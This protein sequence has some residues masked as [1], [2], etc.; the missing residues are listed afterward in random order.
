MARKTP[1][2][3]EKKGQFPIDLY[4]LILAVIVI[5]PLIFSKQVKD[6]VMMPRFLALTVVVIIISLINLARKGKS[7]DYRF[8][9]LYIFPVF[10]L[11]FLLSVFSLTQALNPWE[12]IFEVLR[13]LLF[14]VFLVLITGIFIKEKNSFDL[15]SKFIGFT[16]LFAVLIGLSQYFKYV[17]GVKDSEVFEAIYNVK[18]LM[19]HKNQYAIS[20]FLMLPFTLYGIFKFEKWW[21]YLSIISSVMIA[22]MVVLLQTRSVWLAGSIF[23]AS[24]VFFRLLNYFINREKYVSLTLK[25]IIKVSGIIIIL[26]AVIVILFNTTGTGGLA[27]KQ[28]SSLFEM[29]S[30]N[31]LGRLN[32]WGS[33][34]DLA[35]DNFWFGVGEG[36]WKIA[37]LPYSNLNLGKSYQNWQ[38][39][40]ND[41]LWVLTEKGV[42]G[43]IFYLLIFLTTIIYG[44]K[45]IFKET[46]SDRILK[47][48]LLICGIAGYMVIANLTFP[49][50]RINHQIFLMIFLALIVAMH[51]KPGEESV[52]KNKS[53]VLSLNGFSLII[54]ILAVYISIVRI[55]AEVNMQK[56]RRAMEASNFKSMMSF[57]EKAYSNLTQVDLYSNPLYFYIAYGYEKQNDYDKAIEYYLLAEKQFP[58]RYS[59]FSNMGTIYNKR[60]ELEK[61]IEYYDKSLL[62]YPHDTKSIYNKAVSYYQLGKYEKSFI[63]L[64]NSD[65][66][67]KKDRYNFM[68]NDLKSRLNTVNE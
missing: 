19:G 28:I 25:S 45:I 38:R 47:S 30:S 1:K 33:S 37:V 42:F 34:V 3:K 29:Q 2:V 64:L 65:P 43:L 22:V 5:I 62:L 16:S 14:L 61:A 68:L 31:N 67:D 21:K 10:G 44:L 66:S 58:T 60:G 12:G 55:N 11:Y 57:T 48:T 59:H 18:G 8:L 51:Y 24:F 39:P 6:P 27:K 4:F 13:T 53:L 35:K 50:E 49:M 15:L 52:Y 41:F 20:L 7:M 26:I 63:A 9:Q 17:P 46:D 54:A 40:H 32:S 56:A 36:N 23:F